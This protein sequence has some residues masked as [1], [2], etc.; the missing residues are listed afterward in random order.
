MLEDLI[1]KTVLR[2]DKPRH[3]LINLSHQWFLEP[4]TCSKVVHSLKLY[5]HSG[6]EALTGYILKS[7]RK[8]FVAYS[9]PIK[10]EFLSR[11]Q[12]SGDVKAPQTILICSQ[13]C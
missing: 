4:L 11:A 12:V 8:L 9:R 1:S 6:T 7:P 2:T 13:G 3:G 5:Q 10:S